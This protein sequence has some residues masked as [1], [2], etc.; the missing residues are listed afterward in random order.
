M[1]RRRVADQWPRPDPSS[2]PATGDDAYLAVA[3]ARLDHQ[4]STI[5]ALDSKAGN[6]LTAALAE[7]G[8]LVALLAIRPPSDADPLSPGALWAMGVAGIAF[9]LV[10]AMSI[11]GLVVR[12]WSRYPG[13]DEA[14]SMAWATPH[15][16][17]QLAM[18]VEQ[19]YNQNRS[20]ELRKADFVRDGAVLLAVQTVVTITACLLV[21]SG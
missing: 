19:A 10:F 15:V 18:S 20:G 1:C 9:V 17:W 21:V 3:Q 8:F 13:P 6:I 5:D 16:A 11:A 4:L 2:F 12:K 7:C 14:W